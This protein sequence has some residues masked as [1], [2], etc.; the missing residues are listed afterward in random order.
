MFL[1]KCKCGCFFTLKEAELMKDGIQKLNCP[2]C[3]KQISF[4]QFTSLR[5]NQDLPEQID[6]ITRIPDHAKITVTFDA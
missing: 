4:N 5:D 1:I 2:N 3:K 6:S